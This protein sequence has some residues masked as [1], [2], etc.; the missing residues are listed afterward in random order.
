MNNYKVETKMIVKDVPLSF[1]SPSG[2]TGSITIAE[3]V[4]EEVSI[5]KQKSLRLN[6]MR[7]NEIIFWALTTKQ[8]QLDWMSN[9]INQYE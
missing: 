5:G 2:C 1:P 6:E 9:Y 3:P 7:H 8:L 4:V